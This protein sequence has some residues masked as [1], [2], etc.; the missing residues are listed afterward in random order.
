MII[1][2]EEGQEPGIGT[3]HR[4]LLEGAKVR[5]VEG[6]SLAR[7]HTHFK[8]KIQSNRQHTEISNLKR[9]E[10][11]ELP[12]K[13]LDYFLWSHKGNINQTVLNGN[14]PKHYLP[15]FLF[16]FLKH[17]RDFMKSSCVAQ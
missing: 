6:T 9:F 5:F 7:T 4:N 2:Q 12:A 10:Q 14:T 11:T 17:P 1:A 16:L 15:T 3:W 8:K 13:L